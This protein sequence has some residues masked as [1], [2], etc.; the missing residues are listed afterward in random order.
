MAS[1]KYRIFVEGALRIGARVVYGT[2]VSSDSVG[3]LQLEEH[4]FDG[5][6]EISGANI[7]VEKSMISNVAVVAM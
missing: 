6:T 2:T 4:Y 7:P 3:D 1:G 5:G